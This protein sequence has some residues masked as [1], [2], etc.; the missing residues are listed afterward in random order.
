MKQS[1]LLS[2]TL[3]DDWTWSY[4]FTSGFGHLRNVWVRMIYEDNSSVDYLVNRSGTDYH[5]FNYTV[6]HDLVHTSAVYKFMF[7]NDMGNITT[8][9]EIALKR[10]NIYITEIGSPD[11]IIDLSDTKSFTV[12]FEIEEYNEYIDYVYLEYTFD[13]GIG[14]NRVNL[15]STTS[16]YNYTFDS[17]SPEVTSLTYSA[18]AVDIYGYE[19]QLGYGRI[20]DL[21]PE[22]P[23]WE[24]SSEAQIFLVILSLIIGVTF[25]LVYH[26]EMNRRSSKG[27]NYEKSLNI[28]GIK[29]D[30]LVK[31]DQT[32]DA[33]VPP[34]DENEQKVIEK[35]NKIV[36]SVF[37][38]VAGILG[39]FGLLSYLLLNSIT[40]A[41]LFFIGAFL[42]T[43]TLWIFL[44]ARTVEKIFRTPNY[45]SVSRDKLFLML[46]SIFIY[47]FIVAI[48]LA[49]NS[50]AW[51]RVRVNELS[52]NIAGFVIP[53]ALTTVTM[54]FLTSIF[55]LTAS[56]FKD[57]AEK[58]DEL[59]IAQV[60]NE[61]P[62][63]IAKTRE[64]AISSSI[65]TIG[66]KGVIFVVIIS[67][68]IVFASDLN[69]YANQGILIMILFLIGAL[70]T[71]VLVSQLSKEKISVVDD[72][73]LDHIILCPQCKSKTALGG[74]YC[75][76]CGKKLLSGQRYT[77]GIIC[78]E[79]E[80]INAQ[81]SEFCR[82][83]GT[84]LELETKPI[85][86][87]KRKKKR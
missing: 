47:I 75:E 53:K 48:F 58:L 83:C 82:Y 52:Y 54:T 41:M 34:L 64:A 2:P 27:A 38:S 74:N 40:T 39:L 42:S 68:V 20:I 6:S 60:F 31:V 56:T 11:S 76:S 43:I 15:S 37:I 59:E 51:W 35:K 62:L 28:F 1:G 23:T 29:K 71:L 44:T 30:K 14:T 86:K 77:S 7:R 69:A 67:L 80:R 33:S 50:L 57:V 87:G 85:I 61:N 22:L 79:C 45:A 8:I 21:I 55:L 81:K 73:V 3:Y 63:N 66:K 19:I 5:I 12:N 4:I 72:I 78:S 46:I 16:S 9:E 70:A 49:G 13:A 26:T 25:G 32:P 65:R 18:V 84:T 17:F 24:M 10:P 36:I